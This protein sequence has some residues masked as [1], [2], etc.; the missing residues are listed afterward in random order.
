MAMAPVVLRVWFIMQSL[1]LSGFGIGLFFIIRAQMKLEHINHQL[2]YLEGLVTLVA[3]SWGEKPEAVKVL[4]D[5][6]VKAHQVGAGDR[7]QQAGPT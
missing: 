2:T 5:I 7:H 4:L 6:Y 3:T 1:I